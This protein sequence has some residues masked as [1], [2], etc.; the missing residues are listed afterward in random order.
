MTECYVYGWV[1]PLKTFKLQV[2]AHL[3]EDGSWHVA[4]PD[5]VSNKIKNLYDEHVNLILFAPIQMFI[6]GLGMRVTKGEI[7]LCEIKE[8]DNG[9]NEG[10]IS[11]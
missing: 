1:N 2:S 6:E 3:G 5:G 7:W 10:T 4:Y 8:V 11:C 9:D